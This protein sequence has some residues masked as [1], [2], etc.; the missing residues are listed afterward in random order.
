MADMLVQVEISFGT[1]GF[2]RSPLKEPLHGQGNTGV[3]RCVDQPTSGNLSKTFVEL[4]LSNH[5]SRGV[6]GAYNLL[7]VRGFVVS[8]K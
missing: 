8:Y 1:Q 2:G 3:G 5:L 6:K 7:L 4:T